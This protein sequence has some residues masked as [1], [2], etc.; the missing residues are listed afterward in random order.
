VTRRV[1]WIGGATIV[2]A[3]A[4]GGIAALVVSSK[5]RANVSPP[6]AHVAM[7]TGAY[8]YCERRL[9]A[10]LPKETDVNVRAFR[11]GRRS[12][13][14][15]ADGLVSVIGFF[16]GR[17]FGT[18]AHGEYRCLVRHTVGANYELIEL[19]MHREPAYP[20]K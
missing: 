1:K 3:L 19:K 15:I 10:A 9:V 20:H 13:T 17:V 12:A 7:R 5:R 4:L 11:R 16:D 2:L 8:H 18:E 14:E 6:D